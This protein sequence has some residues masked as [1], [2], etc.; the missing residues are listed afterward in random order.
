MTCKQDGQHLKRKLWPFILHCN[1]LDHYLH[2]AEFVICTDHK[3]LKYLFE[4]PMHN[5]KIQLWALDIPGYNCK[6]E[7]IDGKENSC[8]DLVTH[9]VGANSSTVEGNIM[10]PDISEN[11]LEISAINSNEF[12][13]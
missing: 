7:D 2:N 11:M 4:A 6:L 13:P 12:D 9:P 8:V 10:E 3:P 1:V 5:K